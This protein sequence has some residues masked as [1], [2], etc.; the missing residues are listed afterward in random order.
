M[1]C[2][3]YATQFSKIFNI[4]KAN[5]TWLYDFYP[6]GSELKVVQNN[7]EMWVGFFFS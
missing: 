1:R 6:A 5:E 7:C 2:E 4:G 3:D